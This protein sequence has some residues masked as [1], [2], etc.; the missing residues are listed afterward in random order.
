MVPSTK[1][2]KIQRLNEVPTVKDGSIFVFNKDSH[3]FLVAAN[4]ERR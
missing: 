1:K 3:L 2:R 4:R